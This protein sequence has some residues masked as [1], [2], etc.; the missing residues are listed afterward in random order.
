LARHDDKVDP[1]GEGPKRKKRKH[2]YTGVDKGKLEN[3]QT[4]PIRIGNAPRQRDKRA[5]DLEAEQKATP[6]P[7]HAKGGCASAVIFGAL[8]LAGL[9]EVV[10][11][12]V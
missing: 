10:R 2:P 11:W 3:Q 4:E 8:G 9:E 5:Q 12:L 6:S 7:K 1:S